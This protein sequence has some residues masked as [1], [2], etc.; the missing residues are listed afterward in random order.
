[1]FQTTGE[2]AVKNELN[3]E[4][5][6]GGGTT[7]GCG[8]GEQRNDVLGAVLQL[9][10]I[11]LSEQTSSASLTNKTT[12]VS[13]TRSHCMFQTMFTFVSTSLRQQL[14]SSNQPIVVETCDF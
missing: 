7:E 14:L 12:T 2:E 3:I 1:M 13:N 9:S 10:D 11:M 4:I 8:R 6:E 5:N